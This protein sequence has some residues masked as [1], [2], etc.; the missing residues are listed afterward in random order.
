MPASRRA[1]GE[2]PRSTCAPLTRKRYHRVCVCVCVCGYTYTY[3]R[4]RDARLRLSPHPRK[5]ERAI[6]AYKFAPRSRFP[7]S[8]GAPTADVE[9]GW[10][11]QSDDEVKFRFGCDIDMKE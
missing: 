8:R 1:R 5:R 11:T 4:A 2:R 10:C 7:L 6:I 9:C 3:T